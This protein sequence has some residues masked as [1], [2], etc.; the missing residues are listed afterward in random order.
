MITFCE[1]TL[2]NSRVT[3]FELLLTMLK[4]H[5]CLLVTSHASHAS[6]CP[7]VMSRVNPLPSSSKM[8]YEVCSLLNV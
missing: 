8:G 2:I 4:H 6:F 7:H 3:H 5:V 1:R